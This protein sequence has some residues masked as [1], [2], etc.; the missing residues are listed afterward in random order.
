MT[1]EVPNYVDK[2]K[3]EKVR[4][5]IPYPKVL[6]ILIGGLGGFI[7]ISLLYLLHAEWQVV[8]CFVVPFGASAVLVFAAPGAPF[9]QPRN[10]IGGHVISALVGI[11][12]VII[13]KEAHWWVLAL[14]NAIAIILMMATKTVH[15]PAGA[16]TF[17]PIINQTFSYTWVLLP[18]LVGAVLIVV[19]G[20]IYNNIWAKRRYPSFWW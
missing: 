11:T 7:I 5:G 1:S 18:V 17:L 10:V 12:I 8:L 20:I 2:I 16:T 9:S 14:A 6:D 4:S 3:G 15:P 13:F 19:V